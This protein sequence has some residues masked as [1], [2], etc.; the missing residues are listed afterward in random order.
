MF[1]FARSARTTLSLILLCG[2]V[3]FFITNA[4]AFKSKKKKTQEVKVINGPQMPASVEIENDENKPVPVVIPNKTSQNLIRI[5]CS[6]TLDEGAETGNCELSPD[7][8]AEK[9][10]LIH[11]LNLQFSDGTQG[12]RYQVT[13][14]G[15][16]PEFS[17]MAPP[18]ERTTTEEQR[19][20]R[21]VISEKVFVFVS[22]VVF[23][24]FFSRSQNTTEGTA[25]VIIWGE[26]IDNP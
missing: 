4:E 15:T 8:P 23:N 17:F 2:G 3:L 7:L 5:F 1:R 10:F 12:I 18:T 26:L 6:V 25:R 20:F 13:M 21:S 16:S 9:T 11:Y 24:A 22:G 19:P 14:P